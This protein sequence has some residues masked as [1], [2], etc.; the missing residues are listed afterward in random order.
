MDGVAQPESRPLVSLEQAVGLA[1]RHTWTRVG[2]SIGL[3]AYAMA[4]LV[5]QRETGMADGPWFALFVGGIV[6]IGGLGIR[7]HVG[8]RVTMASASVVDDRGRVVGRADRVAKVEMERKHRP[9]LYGFGAF[10]VSGAALA[11]LTPGTELPVWAGFVA[12]A[13]GLLTW[14]RLRTVRD[15]DAARGADSWHAGHKI[16]RPRQVL[17]D[18]AP[19]PTPRPRDRRGAPRRRR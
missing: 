17:I 18:D 5:V 11:V 7:W 1:T 8:A 16:D 15:R 3:I 9:S 14:Q 2:L 4:T 10:Y 13:I 6:L 12:L 19:I